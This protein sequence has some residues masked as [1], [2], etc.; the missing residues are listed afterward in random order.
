V[1]SVDFANSGHAQVGGS[2]ESL[3]ADFSSMSSHHWC[4]AKM[5]VGYP[6]PPAKVIVLKRSAFGMSLR[7]SPTSSPR[8][9]RRLSLRISGHWLLDDLRGRSAP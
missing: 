4:T 7:Q 5:D 6:L 3:D 1:P 8:V 2:F 9:S